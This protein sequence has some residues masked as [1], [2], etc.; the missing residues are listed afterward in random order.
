MQR[1]GGNFDGNVNEEPD[2]QQLRHVQTKEDRVGTEVLGRRCQLGHVKGI[3]NLEIEDQHGDQH[4]HAAEHGVQKEFDCGILTSRSTPDADEEVH[5]QQHQFP[6]DV[7]EEKIHGAEDADHS[8]IEEKEQREIAFHCALNTPRGEDANRTQENGEQYHRDTDAIQGILTT[9]CRSGVAR[10]KCW[11]SH[12]P[13][14]RGGK[15][16]PNATFLI[17]SSAWLGMHRIAAMPTIGI[18]IM[19]ERTEV[20][21]KTPSPRLSGTQG[22]RL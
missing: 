4:E 13:S 6:K 21:M 3:I 16:T 18:K 10:L 7:K 15:V 22:R 17:K 2:P 20:S 11:N 5:G 1:E 19:R 8:S 14:T 12:I 9:N